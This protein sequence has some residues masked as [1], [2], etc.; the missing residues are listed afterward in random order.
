M[1][2]RKL[3]LQEWFLSYQVKSIQKHH[4][5]NPMFV[6]VD[7]SKLD[8]MY[9]E[10]NKQPHYTA[11]LIKAFAMTAHL[12]PS[13]NQVYFSRFWGD[14]IVSPPTI[15]VNFPHYIKEDGRA[16]LIASIIPSA[17]DKSVEEIYDLIRVSCKKK[18]SDT[19]IAKHFKKNR[20]TFFM[21]AYLRL[22]HFVAYSFP[23]LYLKKGGGGLSVSS[24][25][26][27]A[28]EDFRCTPIAW[29]PTA[30]TL[31]SCSVTTES[32]DRRLLRLGI[33]W[34]HCTGE[35]SDMI[36]SIKTLVN[37]LQGDREDALL[38]LI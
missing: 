28:E 24:L 8:A 2:I 25:L 38:D 14:C 26:N 33:A 18:L 27:Y 4:A 22:I 23:S 16:Y 29:G 36:V 37:I 30:M 12:H 9:R 5:F 15:N 20:N 13:L 6:E 19:I 17:N 1:S 21:R 7:I 31:A 10:K 35:G 3:T 32:D 11:I 34:D